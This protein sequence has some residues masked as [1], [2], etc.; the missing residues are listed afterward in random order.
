MTKPALSLEPVLDA[1]DSA[2]DDSIERLFSLLR[3][4]SISTDPAYKD[5][6]R[7]AANWLAGDLASIGF[8]ASVRDT[9]GHPMVVAH[10][11]G[12]SADAPHVLFYG[13]YDVQPVDPLD[14]RGADH[15]RRAGRGS[16]AR[17]GRFGRH[18]RRRRRRTVGVRADRD[19]EGDAVEGPHR[20]ASRAVAP[21][22][23]NRISVAGRISHGFMP[24]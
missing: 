1:L 23:R 13:H 22:S 24:E 10:H 11:D 19:P 17:G 14:H 8:D 9:D 4:R 18:G 6:C 7:A 5:D 2:V 20:P 21:S 12:P 15:R 16:V 3:I